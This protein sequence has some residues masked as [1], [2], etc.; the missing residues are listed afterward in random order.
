MTTT[1]PPTLDYPT[2]LATVRPTRVI[3]GI[4]NSARIAFGVMLMFVCV[5]R[6]D[7]ARAAHP[8]MPDPLVMNDGTPVATMQQWRARRE[9][10]KSVLRMYLLGNEPAAPGYVT[11]EDIDARE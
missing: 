3:P 1:P 2:P 4:E 5:S 9:E 6:T 10:M 11:G 8:G 7:F